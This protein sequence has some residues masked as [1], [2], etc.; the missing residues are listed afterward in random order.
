MAE[1]PRTSLI[2]GIFGHGTEQRR[3]GGLLGANGLF[4]VR[5]AAA[6]APAGV[7]RGLP[8]QTRIS[9]HDGSKRTVIHGPGR[10][11]ER[12]MGVSRHHRAPAGIRAG[13]GAS[14]ASWCRTTRGSAPAVSPA[15]HAFSV[16][17]RYQPPDVPHR[18]ALTVRSRGRVKRAG[19]S[20]TLHLAGVRPD[21]RSSDSP[22]T[23]RIA[24][25]FFRTRSLCKSFRLGFS[26]RGRPRSRRP[27]CCSSSIREEKYGPSAYAQRPTGRRSVVDG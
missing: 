14:I 18:E 20:R 7:I 21:W 15:R 16:A 9:H 6:N 23:Q 10:P 26:A 22:G 24:H 8:Q 17:L 27:S 3:A 12:P 1:W 13:L 2:R 11:V 25:C 5:G 19:P 4:V